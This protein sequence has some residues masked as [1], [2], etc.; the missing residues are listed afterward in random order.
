MAKAI[1]GYQSA[2][3]TLLDRVRASDAIAW[4]RFTDLYSP[5]VY[6]LCR[7]AG[8]SQTDAADISQEVFLVAATRIAGFRRDEAGQSMRRWIGQ[9]TR[10]KI[11]DWLRNQKTVPSAI[12]GEFSIVDTLADS[13]LDD[14]AM[15]DE[16]PLLRRAIELI[17]GDFSE[18]TWLCF[19]RTVLE[20]CSASVIAQ[21]LKMSAKAVRQA[22]YRVVHRLRTEFDGLIDLRAENHSNTGRTSDLR[23]AVAISSKDSSPLQ[24]HDRFKSQ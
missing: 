21:D 17:R 8:L 3:S 7:R 4:Q 6:G 9:I 16:T 24:K 11:G 19:R 1:R 22:K 20:G 2:S 15:E 23:G 18:T 12:G 10:N 13:V 14:E 5:W